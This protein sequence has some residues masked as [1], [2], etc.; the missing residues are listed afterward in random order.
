MLFHEIT[1]FAEGHRQALDPILDLMQRIADNPLGSHVSAREA[2]AIAKALR[3][4]KRGFDR[5]E[6]CAIDE[7]KTKERYEKK[8]LDNKLLYN[9]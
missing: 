8:L 5:F 6:A 7:W 9:N 4:T 3:T 1:P 2:E